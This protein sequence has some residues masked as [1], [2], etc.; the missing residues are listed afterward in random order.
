LLKAKPATS[1]KRQTEK[2]PICQAIEWQ[3]MLKLDKSLNQSQLADK[4]GVSRAR[5]CQLMRLLSLPK[6]IQS[7]L[8]KLK[9][10]EHIRLLSERKM[11]DVLNLSDQDSQIK[12]FYNLR[13]ESGLFESA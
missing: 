11:R 5:V 13:H 2:H 3:N 12:A 9:D 6:E 4:Q 7:V 8:V 1:S 10:P